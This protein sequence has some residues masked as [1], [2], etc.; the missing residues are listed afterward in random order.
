MRGANADYRRL[1]QSAAWRRLR[2]AWI[3][4]HPLCEDCLAAGRAVPAEEV[5]H[6]CP[7]ERAATRPQMRALCLDPGNLRSLCRACHAE[8][9]RRLR[10]MSAEEREQGHETALR[11]FSDKYFK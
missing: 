1:I 8:A 2:A 7:V 9:H 11:R 5:H 4:A 3:S 6:V 10:S